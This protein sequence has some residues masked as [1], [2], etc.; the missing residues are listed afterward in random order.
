MNSASVVC[1]KVFELAASETAANIA[2]Y[3]EP[4]CGFSKKPFAL[5]VVLRKKSGR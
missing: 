1:A 3:L 4:S 2:T 5:A